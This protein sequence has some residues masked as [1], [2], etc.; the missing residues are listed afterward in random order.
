[1]DVYISEEYVIQRRLEKKA[2]VSNGSKN[3][4]GKFERGRSLE[5]EKMTRPPHYGLQHEYKI[6]SFR[7]NVVFSCFSA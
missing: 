1:M 2:L 5:E 4:N 6:L 7:E 3:P